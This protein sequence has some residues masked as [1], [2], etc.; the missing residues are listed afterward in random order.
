V[1]LATPDGVHATQA[2]RVAEAG[3]HALVE[4]P[5]ALRGDEAR[6]LVR[7]FGERQLAL[8]VGYQLRHHAGHRTV[9]RALRQLVGR[10]R[11]IDVRWSWPDPAVDGWRAQGG[12]SRWWSLA[13]LGTHALDLAL[14]F[15]G[16]PP[17]AAQTVLAMIDQGGPVDRRA[18][19]LLGLPEAVEVS[20]TVSVE[21]RS[22]P[23][24]SLLGD[25]GE[26]EALGTLGARGGGTLTLRRPRGEES[27][28]EFQPEDPYLAQLRDFVQA[29]REGRPPEASG[30]DGA[31]Q[32]ELLER[33]G[34]SGCTLGA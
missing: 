11:R 8:A 25:E 16:R 19:V 6:D 24:L 13:A 34:S 1:V 10:L 5:L 33:L 7:A 21:Y 22:V 32:V 29:L 2:T 18:S 4:K 12:G 28:L 30:A 27:P 31:A 15:A 3:V 23:R 14:W 26:V 17:E 9:R 20:V